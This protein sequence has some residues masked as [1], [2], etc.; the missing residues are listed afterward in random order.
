M[1]IIKSG[2]SNAKLKIDLVS[3]AAR[4]TLYN[5]AGNVTDLPTE[6]TLVELKNSIDILI[7]RT[8][9]VLEKLAAGHIFRSVF[10]RNSTS[11]PENVMLFKNGATK[12]V[13][14]NIFELFFNATAANFWEVYLNPTITDN[15][16]AL[17]AINANTASVITPTAILYDAPTISDVGTLIRAF[18]LDTNSRFSL[19]SP[20]ILLAPNHSILLRR[21][22][23]GAGNEIRSNWQW[24]EQ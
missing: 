23:V 15:G 8:S 12:S 6:T 3:H 22:N 16:T 5:A 17:S 24:T 18:T 20:L 14:F 21:V 13:L 7:G 11:A 1:E 19:S 2:D 10:S 9:S 4:T